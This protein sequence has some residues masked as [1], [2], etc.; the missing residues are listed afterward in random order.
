MTETQAIVTMGYDLSVGHCGADQFRNLQDM[1]PL[2]ND[3]AVSASPD[4]VCG[5]HQLTINTEYAIE[6]HGGMRGLN[7]RGGT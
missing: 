7:C 3:E 4:E 1:A 6:S 2:A 5:V